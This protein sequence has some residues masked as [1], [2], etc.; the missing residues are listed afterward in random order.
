MNPKQTAILPLAAA[1][2]LSA[3]AVGAQAPGMTEDDVRLALESA[4]YTDVR[5]VEFDDGLWE[6]DV[7]S[8][9]GTRIDVRINPG[10]GRIYA[11][12]A[13]SMLTQDEVEAAVTAAGWTNVHDVEFDDGLWKVEADGPDGDDREL[14]VDPEDG[15]IIGG[16]ED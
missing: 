13:V 6:A 14:R 1:I 3:T 10:N 9:D 2:A 5:D 15:S 12:N 4:G 16:E 7:T 8:G 11:D